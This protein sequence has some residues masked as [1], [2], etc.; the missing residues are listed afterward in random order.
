MDSIDKRFA[1]IANNGDRL[2][3][4]KKVQRSTNRYGFALTAPGEQ[5]RNGGGT[6]TE[7]IS[8]VIKRLV[9][10][11]W[12]VRVK[13]I[14]KTGKKR[15]GTLGIDKRSIIG[16]ELEASLNHLVFGAPKQPMNIIGK[17]L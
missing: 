4:Y 3:P 15:E 11:D 2:Y 16:Y 7:D 8:L 1:L 6:Y 17:S 12:N 13:T 14:N 10:D 9:F 5:D